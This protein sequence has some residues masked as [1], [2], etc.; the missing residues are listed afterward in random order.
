MRLSI[1]IATIT[2]CLAAPVQAQEGRSKDI[3]L[4]FE[5]GMSLRDLAAQHL[6]NSDLWAEIL[7]ASNIANIADIKTG[8]KLRIP[9]RVITKAK[10]APQTDWCGD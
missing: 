6:G 3:I 5:P 10:Q 4:S 9:A 1:I 7:N 2:F 8:Q